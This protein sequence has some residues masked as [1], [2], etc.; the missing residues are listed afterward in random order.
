MKD[1]KPGILYKNSVVINNPE[2]GCQLHLSSIDKTFNFLINSQS[3]L[4]TKGGKK[5]RNNLK[6]VGSGTNSMSFC[7]NFT[8]SVQLMI[9]T[10]KQS[11]NLKDS[12]AAFKSYAP[13]AAKVGIGCSLSTDA[14]EIRD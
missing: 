14:A 10:S 6:G 8:P 2:S 4:S 1:M 11:G 7:S 5:S 12:C 13:K 9:P 3:A